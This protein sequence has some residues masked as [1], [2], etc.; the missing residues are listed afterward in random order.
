MNLNSFIGVSIEL[1]GHGRDSVSATEL[2]RTYYSGLNIEQK[3][4]MIHFLPSLSSVFR[5][6]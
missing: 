4:A 1:T 6:F 2:G 3:I 5:T